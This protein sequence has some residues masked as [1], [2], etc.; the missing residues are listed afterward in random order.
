MDICYEKDADLQTEF[1]R[2]RMR[3]MA[4]LNVG[5]SVSEGD[6]RSR[7]IDFIP[8]E[9]S[10]FL[11]QVSASMK[12]LTTMCSSTGSNTAG[13]GGSKLADKVAL[14]TKSLMRMA[15]EEWDRCEAGRRS[16]SG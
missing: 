12:A 6:Y 9:L 5:V 8:H 16:A 1:D 3:Y 2:V 4:L 15:V 10:S 14:D 7:V 11:A 13:D